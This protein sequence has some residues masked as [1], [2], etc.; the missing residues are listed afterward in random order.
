MQLVSVY[1]IASDLVLYRLLEE[2]P[3]FAN[4]SHRKMPGWAKHKRFL[5]SHPYEAWYL[6][7]ESD[8]SLEVLGSIYLTSNAEIGI[9]L[10]EK[11][12]GEGHA[13][14]AIE[15]L[16]DLHPYDRY[17]A[18]INPGNDCSIAMFS[19]LGFTHIQNTYLLDA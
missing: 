12:Q 6:I 15:M 4:I 1:D 14:E 13:R 19:K 7:M 18:N 16:M 3:D 8:S 10:F 9:S 5:D 2:R 11:H 17:F